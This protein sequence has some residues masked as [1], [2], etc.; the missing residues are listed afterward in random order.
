MRNR[1]GY[2][3][4][5]DAGVRNQESEATS[6]SNLLLRTADFRLLT[7]GGKDQ[8]VGEQQCTNRNTGVSHVEGR[9]VIL[10]GVQV[11]EI[12][13]ESEPH[14]IRKI[15]ENA[16]QQQRARTKYAVVSA[17]CAEEIKQDCDRG[18]RSQ[19]DE[20]PAAERAAFLQLPE[21]NAGVLSVNKIKH[22]AND[23]LVS[24]AH[25]ANRPGLT[26]LV[27]KVHAQRSDEIKD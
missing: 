20:K 6:S 15:A 1:M 10:S 17:G 27:H 2:I 9:P 4:T 18:S 19:H 12:D 16:G 13:H 21:R 5:Q 23:R 14:P 3:K 24:K 8:I 11:N 26:T 22:S 7:S 25:P